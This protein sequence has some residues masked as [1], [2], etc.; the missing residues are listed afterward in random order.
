MCVCVCVCVCECVWLTHST[1]EVFSAVVL[2]SLRSE[3]VKISSN[4]TGQKKGRKHSVK[5]FSVCFCCDLL[6]PYRVARTAHVNE[7]YE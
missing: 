5:C 4:S 1:T 2:S 6:R 3:E 7:L